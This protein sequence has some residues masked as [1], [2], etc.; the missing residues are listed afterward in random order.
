[1]KKKTIKKVI[2]TTIIIIMI[3][4]MLMFTL[5]PLFYF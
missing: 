4:A 3:I 1:M 5:A 2:G